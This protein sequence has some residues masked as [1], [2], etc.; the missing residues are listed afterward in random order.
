MK[1]REVDRLT[2]A[3]AKMAN[4]ND[5]LKALASRCTGCACLREELKL[6]HERICQIEEEFH[7]QRSVFHSGKGSQ[8]ASACAQEIH[9][10]GLFGN[11]WANNVVFFFLCRLHADSGA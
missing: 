8:S 11:W 7:L 9:S 6:A 4:E 2:A 10:L 5:Q 3:L 1:T